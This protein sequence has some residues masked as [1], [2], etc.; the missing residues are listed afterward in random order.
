MYS[1]LDNDEIE[2]LYND[3]KIYFKFGDMEA[4]VVQQHG[5]FPL[6]AFNTIISSVKNAE[7]LKVDFSE[8]MVSLKRSAILSG[9]ENENKV[10][11]DLFKDR[12]DFTCD[13][14]FSSSKSQGKY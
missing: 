4:M 13:N 8:F 3:N 7:P 1:L 12:M 11:L 6:A 5:A 14:R 2:L 9:K 10:R